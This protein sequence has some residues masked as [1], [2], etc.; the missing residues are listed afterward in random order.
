MKRPEKTEPVRKNIKKLKKEDKQLK[1]IGSVKEIDEE[2]SEEEIF[3]KKILKK[4]KRL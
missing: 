1:K 4:V 2:L 3:L